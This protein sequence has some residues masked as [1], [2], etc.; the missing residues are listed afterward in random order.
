MPLNPLENLPASLT[1]QMTAFGK[2]IENLNELKMNGQTRE[3]NM[4]EYIKF[5]QCENLDSAHGHPHISPSPSCQ[6]NDLSQQQKV[7]DFCN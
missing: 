7:S 3:R 4:E 5:A 1:R 6:I 2:F